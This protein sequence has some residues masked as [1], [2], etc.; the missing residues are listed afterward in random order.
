[1]QMVSQG[2]KEM[3]H[4]VHLLTEQAQAKTK[5]KMWTLKK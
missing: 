2:L 3:R 4:P 5:F 1:M